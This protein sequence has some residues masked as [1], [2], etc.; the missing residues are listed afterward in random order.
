MSDIQPAQNHEDLSNKIGYSTKIGKQ[1]I[2]AQLRERI[3]E[4][5]ASLKTAIEQNETAA[6]KYHA[7]LKERVKTV[8]KLEVQ[9]DRKISGIRKML[10]G[11]F[12]TPPPELSSNWA[13]VETYSYQRY[14][15]CYDGSRLIENLNKVLEKESVWVEFSLYCGFFN[16]NIVAEGGGKLEFTNEL[17]LTSDLI[18]MLTD[19]RDA[20][21]DVENNRKKL[22]ETESKL[23]SI[24]EVMEQMEAKLLV[25]ELK[26]SEHGRQVLSATSEIISQMLGETPALLESKGE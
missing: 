24:D 20:A 3:T 18:E 14:S 17:E 11:M 25:D 12:D 22:N 5:K 7:A 23:S 6:E 21:V 1:V 26:A 10:A 9:N 15:G 16:E 4:L 19:Y 8:L 2:K 13:F